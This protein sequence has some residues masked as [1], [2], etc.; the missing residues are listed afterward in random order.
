MV[1]LPADLRVETLTHCLLST[2]S[3]SK[4]GLSIA[5]TVA[6][7]TLMILTVFRVENLSA[8]LDHLEYRPVIG[9]SAEVLPS[10]ILLPV[11]YT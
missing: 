11:C 4:P 5:S 10:T 2:A 8:D 9:L 1:R 3:A 6:A 7:T